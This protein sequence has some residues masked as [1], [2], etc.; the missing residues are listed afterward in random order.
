VLARLIVERG[1]IVSG[2]RLIEDLYADKALAAV[3]SYVSHLRRE[4]E[5]NRTARDPAR[6]LVTAPPGYAVRLGPEAVDAWSFEDDVH[7][8]VQMDNP[9]T[10]HARLSA[11][12]ARPGVR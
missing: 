9:A 10:T 8:A 5:P 2:D 12:L 7:Q 4:L 1:R 11:A 6:V 3:Q